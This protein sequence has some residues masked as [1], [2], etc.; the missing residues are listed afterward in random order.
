[1]KQLLRLMWTNTAIDLSAPIAIATK[2]L[3][4]W[5]TWKPFPTKPM[6]EFRRSGR[7]VFAAPAINVIEHKESLDIFT[8]TST[9]W[10]LLTVS[11][12]YLMFQCSAP[13]PTRLARRVAPFLCHFCSLPCLLSTPQRAL[14]ICTL[15]CYSFFG[16]SPFSTM[17][18]DRLDPLFGASPFSHV[19]FAASHFSP[20]FFALLIVYHEHRFYAIE[21]HKMMVGIG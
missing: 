1:M 8:A 20:P 3:K 18:F 9:C 12:E 2:H 13:A 17:F 15:G 14:S 7:A 5:F 16:A 19:L 21:S 4:G 6:V 10:Y 11:N